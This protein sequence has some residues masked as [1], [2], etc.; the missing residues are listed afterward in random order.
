MEHE[1]AIAIAPEDRFD[2]KEWTNCCMYYAN[3]HCMVPV[4]QPET[5]VGALKDTGN[6]SSH[7]YVQAHKVHLV[8]P[9][10]L[11]YKA[12][13][14]WFAFLPTNIIQKTFGSTTQY[15]RMPYNTILRPLQGTSPSLESLSEGGTS[16][17][18]HDR[19]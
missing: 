10:T 19:V 3:L 13:C 15:V 16:C 12:L 7:P 6:D 18:G 1:D 2:I 17:N 11:D 14:S 5:N 8:T 9:T 4:E